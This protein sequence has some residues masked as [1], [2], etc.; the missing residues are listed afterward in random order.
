MKTAVLIVAAGRGSRAGGEI[1]KQYRDLKDVP[2]LR[3]TLEAFAREPGIACIQ[4]V[5]HRDDEHLWRETIKGLDYAHLLPPATGGAERQG[6]VSA[7]LEALSHAAPDRVL[8]HDAARPFVNSGVIGRVLEGLNDAPA[9]LPA[10]PIVDALWH[11]PEGHPP[12]SVDRADLWRAQTPQGFDYQ[13]IRKLH[14]D[15]APGAPDD[16]TL[17]RAAGLNVAVVM[18]DGNNFKIT[19]PEDFARGDALLASQEADMPD[20]RTGIGYDVHAF[21]PG[22]S[23]VLNGVEIAHDHA[24]KG[25]SDAD[26]AMH[27]IT[28]ALFGA[29]AE[30]DIGQWFP[31]SEAAWK[32]AASHIFLEKARERV[33]ARGYRISHI[34]CTI[35]CEAPKIGPHAAAMQARLADILKLE[36]GR[37]SV[38][39]TTSE[40]L[41]FTGREEGIAATAV[42]TLV[43]P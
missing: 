39:A 43:A 42:A 10:L 7:G 26:V 33:A 13:S 20:V 16:I 11:V 23:V 25:H 4:V 12:E 9:V 1:P 22:R 41:G 36:A 6:S 21:E 19:M 5:I 32:G 8:I 27:A 24:L 38:K 37:I 35:I 29:I 14:R 17:A 3:R 40:R 31:P 18:G 34:D 28:D 2:V 15:A 30:G